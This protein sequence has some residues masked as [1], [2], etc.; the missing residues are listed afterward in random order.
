MSSELGQ[1][2][3][4]ALNSVAGMIEAIQRQSCFDDRDQAGAAPR[5]GAAVGSAAVAVGD[6]DVLF[7]AVKSRLRLIAHEPQGSTNGAT[8]D[9]ALAH[10][11]ANVLECVA[12]LDQLHV[13]WRQTMGLAAPLDGVTGRA[14]PPAVVVP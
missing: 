3:H 4:D 11:Q 1:G 8:I 14:D 2:P 10:I 12:A 7:D 13:A 9:A 5:G 6:W